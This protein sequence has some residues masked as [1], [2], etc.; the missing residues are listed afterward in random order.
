MRPSIT[1]RLHILAKERIGPVTEERALDAADVGKRVDAVL[2]EGLEE[3]RGFLVG[4]DGRPGAAGGGG[5][6]DSG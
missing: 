5:G 4:R 3:R 1:N 2:A 6:G